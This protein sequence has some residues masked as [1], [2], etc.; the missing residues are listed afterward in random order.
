M[1]HSYF[2]NCVGICKVLQV[3]TWKRKGHSFAELGLV[4]CR[5]CNNKVFEKDVCP[6]LMCPCCQSKVVLRPRSGKHLIL[7]RID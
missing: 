6:G 3:T 5:N 4:M 1:N 2:I 7:K